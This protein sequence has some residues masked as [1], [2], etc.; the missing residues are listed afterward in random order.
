ML[1]VTL[2][3][4]VFYMLYCFKRYEECKLRWVWNKAVLKRNLH[5]GG[6]EYDSTVVYAINDSGVNILMNLFSVQ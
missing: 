4:Q 2:L 5:L 3:V 1:M 6:V